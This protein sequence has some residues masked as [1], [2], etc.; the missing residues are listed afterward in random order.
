MGD[1][2]QDIVFKD[3]SSQELENVATLVFDF[4][5]SEEIISHKMAENVLGAEKGY[6]PGKKWQKVVEYLEEKQFL[7]LR[8]NGVR[9]VKKRNIFYADGREFDAIK[10]PNCGANN[11]ECDWGELFV[12]WQND[13]EK[14]GLKCKNCQRTNSISEFEFE[15]VWALS[16]LGFVF[17]N[18]PIFKNSFIAELQE[19][20]GKRIIK[21]EGKL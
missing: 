7:D 10:C 13:P 12:K 4:L 3:V 8:T 11:L 16:N 15:P 18:W 6:V 2:H 19:L 9:I 5:I 17:W 1:W 14:S 21:V 20:T